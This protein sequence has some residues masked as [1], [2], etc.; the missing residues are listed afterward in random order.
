M[1][2]I[3]LAGTAETAERAAPR[4]RHWYR[5][6]ALLAGAVLLAIILFMVIAAPLLTAYNPDTQNQTGGSRF[7][8]PE[9]PP[10]FSQSMS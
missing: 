8:I 4:R 5:Q 3:S 6:P 1:S 7:H 9:L 10:V 2:V